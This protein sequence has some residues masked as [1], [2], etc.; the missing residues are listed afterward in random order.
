MCSSDLPDDLSDPD[1]WH[2]PSALDP[3]LKSQGNAPSRLIQQVAFLARH[4]EARYQGIPQD[5]EWTFDGEDRK[6]VV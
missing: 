5:V 6:S 3:T 1:S 4:L 2:L